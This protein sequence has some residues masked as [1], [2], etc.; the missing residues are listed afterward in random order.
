MLTAW[1]Q[2]MIGLSMFGAEVA[3]EIMK[4]RILGWVGGAGFVMI[5]IVFRCT[6]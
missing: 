4:P 1:S 3:V 5:S 2:G 6:I